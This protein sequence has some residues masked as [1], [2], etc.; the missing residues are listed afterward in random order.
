MVLF[1]A[2]SNKSASASKM[3]AAEAEVPFTYRR[4]PAGTE[5][6][7]ASMKAAVPVPPHFLP[8]TTATTITAPPHHQMGKVL[9]QSPREP[10]SF[11]RSVRVRGVALQQL[12]P[13]LL[14][15]YVRTTTLMFIGGLRAFTSDCPGIA[16]GTAAAV[17]GRGED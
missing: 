11:S 2:L 5:K 6:M 10:A 17:A 12:Q 3:K 14:M 13:A 7:T 16:C 8:P 9:W 15:M 4:G 1:V